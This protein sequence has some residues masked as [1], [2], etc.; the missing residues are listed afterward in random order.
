MKPDILL[1]GPIH[2]L[3]MK[4]LE[5]Q[6]SVYRFWEAWDRVP[7]LHSIKDRIR[8]IVVSP[9]YRVDAE[10]MDALPNAR[11]ISAITI[12]VDNIDLA[13]AK[14]RGIGVT[15]TP[16]VLTDDVADIAIVLLIS[17]TRRVVQA[18]RY[19]RSGGWLKGDMPLTDKVGGKTMGV[20]GLGRIGL[21]VAK[22]AGVFGIDVVYNGPRS[23][24]DV[25]YRYYADLAEMAAASHY[26]MVTC[27]G[28]DATRHIVNAKILKALGPK[29]IVINVAR[30]SVIDEQ[31][32][33]KALA[34]GTIGGAG[35]DVFANEPMVPQA[36]H[37]RDDVVL[38]PHVG[39]ATES[40][41]A[42]MGQLVL[43]NL[44]A[45]FAGQQLVTPVF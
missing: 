23:K 15:N 43:D 7:F 37:T 18:D 44:H 29:G 4:R 28:G 25:P 20:L 9:H 30:G 10:L 39:S 3:T 40:T 41:R 27:P 35:L 24:P 22:R 34:D 1:T 17:V 12:G 8:A 31:A 14:A 16:E 42:A 26:L 5:E 11:L 6:F 33:L 13:A 2:A 32:L 38:L 19:V 45:F 21:A 36:L